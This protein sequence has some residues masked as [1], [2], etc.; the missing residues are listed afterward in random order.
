MK[1]DEFAFFNQQL[2]SMLKDGIPLEGALKQLCK[3]MRSGRLRHELEALGADLAAGV[4]LG[5]ALEGRRLPD[6]YVRMLQVGVKA[7]NLAGVL[8]LMSDH[9]RKVN[10]ITRRLTGMLV[11]PAI[12]LVFSLGVSIVTFLMFR[13]LTFD[14]S[15]A[16][17]YKSQ[18][19][20]SMGIALFI[21]PVLFG[22]LATAFAIAVSVPYVR[23]SLA[24][25]LPP[26]KHG[27]LAQI[28]SAM[29]LMLRG[30]CTLSESLALMR[31]VEKGSPAEAEFARWQADI[32]EGVTELDEMA[33]GSVV[34]P[35][36]FIWLAAH[37]GSDLADGF[38]QAAKMYDERSAHGTE[39]MLYGALPVSV[40]ILG[41][42][43]L[44]QGMA[45]L[46]TVYRFVNLMGGG[47]I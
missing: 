35:P 11:Y 4:P 45:T 16:L 33:Y 19:T 30:G 22:G 42:V 44:T 20:V 3:S 15:D 43:V 9:Y 39:L 21:G 38:E 6:L 29:A 41:V 32:E 17:G 28:A 25:W 12:V 24:W 7:N 18:N 47:F 13:S 26:F 10:S 46:G 31:N 37:S 27:K 8:T 5:Q 23:R 2:A 14:F 36:L 40:V 1:H 34:F